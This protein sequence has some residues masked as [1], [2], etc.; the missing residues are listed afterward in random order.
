MRRALLAP[1]FAVAFVL[2]SGGHAG[3]LLPPPTGSDAAE[4]ARRAEDSM[5]S[6]RGR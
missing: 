1:L 6:P 2:A 4:I 3:E 5:R